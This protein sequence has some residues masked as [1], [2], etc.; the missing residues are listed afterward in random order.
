MGS[1][2]ID[3]VKLCGNLVK[4]LPGNERTKEIISSIV[5]LSKSLNFKVLA[6]FVE[7]EEQKEALEQVG[8]LLKTI[9]RTSLLEKLKQFFEK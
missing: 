1:A 7:T 9:D 6:E 5:F 8:C 2:C 3:L 4:S